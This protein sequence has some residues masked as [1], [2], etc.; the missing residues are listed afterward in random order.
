MCACVCVFVFERERE[1][2]CV[3]SACMFAATNSF[4]DPAKGRTRGLGFKFFDD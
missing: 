1:G 3:V 4:G 2:V